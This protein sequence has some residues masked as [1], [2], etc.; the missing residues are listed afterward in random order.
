MALD[1]KLKSRGAHDMRLPLISVFLACSACSQSTHS[2]VPLS[3]EAARRS[4]AAMDVNKDGFI[5]HEEWAAQESRAAAVM[6]EVNRKE[7]VGFLEDDFKKFDLNG[8]GKISFAEWMS[9]A[10]PEV[11]TL[12]G[13]GH[14]QL[15][16]DRVPLIG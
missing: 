11:P 9:H 4:L 6:P 8:D 16:S 10:A 7:Y 3:G 13:V 12:R 14:N 5:S 1:E 2:K 15:N